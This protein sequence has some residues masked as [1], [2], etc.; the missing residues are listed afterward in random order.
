MAESRAVAAR[1]GHLEL[2]SDL[3]ARCIWL[4]SGMHGHTSD[5]F[6]D[7]PIQAS[8]G[9]TWRRASPRPRMSLVE[10]CVV[11]RGG[12]GPYL[13]CEVKVPH[14]HPRLVTGV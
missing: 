4:K 5:P 14:S 10:P 11:P 2:G 3:C 9:T 13:I 1:L 7:N 6:C 12:R 8:I